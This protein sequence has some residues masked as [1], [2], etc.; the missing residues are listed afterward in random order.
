M[1]MQRTLIA[2]VIL[3]VLGVGF[4]FINVP[5]GAAPEEVA[6]E[7]EPAA[8]L[9]GGTDVVLHTTF[10]DIAI[11]LFTEE[12]PETT[13]HFLALARSGFYDGVKFHRAIAGFMVQAGDPLTK[14]DS[15]VA[16]WGTGGPGYTIA[17]EFV[18]GLSNVRG[19]L[20]MANIGVP[21][22]GGSQFFI[23]VTDNTGLDFDKEP[24]SSKHPVFGRVVSGMEVVDAI[25]SVP[26]EGPDRPVTSVIIERVST[27]S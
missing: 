12:A 8:T 2:I 24:L 14:D 27:G 3:S 16:R 17:D 15:L 5:R 20:A 11:D 7:G 4:Y 22:S 21:N 18:P 1:H 25:A 6:L 19:T 13:E 10:G 23:N 26:T 9:T